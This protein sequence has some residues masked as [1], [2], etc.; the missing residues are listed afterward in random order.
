MAAVNART[1]TITVRI[2][3]K[4]VRGLRRERS[5]SSRSRAASAAFAWAGMM[6]E[7]T[8]VRS[9]QFGGSGKDERPQYVDG[10][11]DRQQDE[12]G[13]H[14]GAD[15]Q[16]AGLGELVGEQRGQRVRRR[17]QRQRQLVGVAHE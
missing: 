16:V 11:G 2:A 4:S 5:R 8:S 3:L 10:Q 17:Q 1:K 9:F 15:L 13:V 7:D 12:G 14:K 6:V